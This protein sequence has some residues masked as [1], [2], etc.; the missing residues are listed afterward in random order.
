MKK[1]ILPFLALLALVTMSF[2]LPNAS[3]VEA[4][5]FK[6]DTES[7]AVVPAEINKLGVDD[8]LNMTPAKYKK[9][10]G[11]KLGLKNTVMLKVAQKK[12]KKAMGNAPS[13]LD[14]TLYIV[15]AIFI[16]FV[17]VG[18]A[19]DWQGSNWIIALVLSLLC[20]IPGMIYALIKMKDYYG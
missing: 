14:K 9:L 11:K 19:S 3:A 20:W 4:P 2:S 12:M 10:T 16:P 18:I 5:K 17:A 6:A 13:D 8:L 7:K 1:F 15:L